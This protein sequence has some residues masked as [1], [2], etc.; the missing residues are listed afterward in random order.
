LK[1]KYIGSYLPEAVRV[2][3]AP[4][5]FLHL[6]QLSHINTSFNA[7]YFEALK[8]TSSFPVWFVGNTL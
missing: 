8:V 7:E 2:D 4:I 5:F 1:K 3:K 6:N